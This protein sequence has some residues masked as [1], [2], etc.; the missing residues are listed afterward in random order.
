MKRIAF[1]MKLK[2][3]MVE[4]YKSKHET[5][6]P[7]LKALLKEAGIAEYSIFFDKETQSLFAFQ[8]VNGHENSQDLGKEEIV[9]KWWSYMAELMEVNH[10]N[11]P[12]TME[13]K[14]V[15]YLE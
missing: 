11:S 5:I 15:F 3:G 7:E 14:E 12:V 2:P 10:D 13:L 9:R 1:K 6:W 8:K 4:E